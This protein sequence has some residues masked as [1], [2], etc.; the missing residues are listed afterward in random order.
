MRSLK[1]Y[2]SS[3]SQWFEVD[4]AELAKASQCTLFAQASLGGE[5]SFVEGFLER[6]QDPISCGESD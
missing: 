4:V 5:E 6:F 1:W 2:Y 3:G